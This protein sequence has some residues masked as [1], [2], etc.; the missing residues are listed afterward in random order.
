MTRVLIAA[1]LAL[2]LLAAGCGKKGALYLPDQKKDEKPEE[3]S[4]PPPSDPG[5]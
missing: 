3:T 4:T 2:S 1:L 5:Y